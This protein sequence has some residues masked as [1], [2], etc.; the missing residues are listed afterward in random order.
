MMN[1]K[2][3]FASVFGLSVAPVVAKAL[4]AARLKTV[5][6]E[7][8]SVSP[9]GFVACRHL[10][11]AE[12]ARIFR[13]PVHMLADVRHQPTLQAIEANTRYSTRY[14]QGGGRSLSL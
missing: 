1:R 3:F 11:V 2:Q 13:V 7:V 12:L 9:P 6:A 4:P 8:V 10:D 14:L 5:I